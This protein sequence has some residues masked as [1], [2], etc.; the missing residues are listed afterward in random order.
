VKAIV[1]L[2]LVLVL[3]GCATPAAPDLRDPA[4]YRKPVPH[5][6]VPTP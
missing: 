1:A 6:P 3:S 4:R 2:A 5:Y